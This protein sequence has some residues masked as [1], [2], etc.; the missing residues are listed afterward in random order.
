ME[1]NC[2]TIVCDRCV[3]YFVA[4]IRF[5]FIEVIFFAFRDSLVGCILMTESIQGGARKSERLHSA[6]VIC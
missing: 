5:S 4:K 2:C 6:S 3:D 1:D